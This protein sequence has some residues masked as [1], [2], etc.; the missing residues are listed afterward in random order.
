L[1]QSALCRFPLAFAEPMNL[2]ISLAKAGRD[3]AL[4]VR[5][6]LVLLSLSLPTRIRV[7]K[8]KL[9]FFARVLRNVRVPRVPAKRSTGGQ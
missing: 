6:S 3:S 1:V 7:V 4:Q 9:W 2:L 5:G 8:L